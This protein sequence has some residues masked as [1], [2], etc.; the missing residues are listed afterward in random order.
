[1]AWWRIR[2]RPVSGPALGGLLTNQIRPLPDMTAKT[3]QCDSFNPSRMI[4]VAF[5]S[6]VRQAPD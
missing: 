5:P 6:G 4:V 3:F 2:V 1:M